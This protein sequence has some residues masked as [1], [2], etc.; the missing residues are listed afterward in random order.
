MSKQKRVDSIMQ[1]INDYERYKAT[2]TDFKNIWLK[3]IPK[4]N[5]FKIGIGN[6]NENYI[7]LTMFD[8]S[9]IL[10]IF[11]MVFDS[12]CETHGKISF[13]ILNET[14][15][16]E[17]IWAIYFDKEGVAKKFIGQ[18]EGQFHMQ[19]KN[20]LEP[21]CLSLLEKYFQSSKFQVSE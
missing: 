4:D 14:S 13:E 19:N 6:V 17:P 11:S 21:L 2:F 20:F 7:E 15:P 1:A 8:S 5:Y 12:E 9:I 3:D 10:A 16:N 18:E